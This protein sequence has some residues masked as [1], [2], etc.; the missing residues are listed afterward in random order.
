[1]AAKEPGAGYHSNSPGFS[2]FSLSVYIESS[3]VTSAQSCFWVALFVPLSRPSIDVSN[4]AMLEEGWQTAKSMCT[5]L[6]F[7]K[8]RALLIPET[9]F[10][11]TLLPSEVLP[12]R[13]RKPESPSYASYSH[14]FFVP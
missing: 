1:M 2:D 13:P 6:A 10:S 14:P 9:M 11:V 7:P 4:S 5:C 8:D 3:Q 12:F